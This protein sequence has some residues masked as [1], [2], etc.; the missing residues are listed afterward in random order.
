MNLY[1]YTN[2]N[3]YTSTSR[4]L[5]LLVLKYRV[6]WYVL[7]RVMKFSLQGSLIPGDVMYKVS[8]DAKNAAHNVAYCCCHGNYSQCCNFLVAKYF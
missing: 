7:Y 6:F 3:K 2:S 5:H 1:S 8:N 4:Y